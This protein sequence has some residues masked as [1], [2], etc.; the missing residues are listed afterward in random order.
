MGPL[1]ECAPTITSP[2]R[3]ADCQCVGQG[4]SG[5]PRDAA[6]PTN[7]ASPRG[8]Q[9]AQGL[10]RPRRVAGPRPVPDVGAPARVTGLSFS[11]HPREGE[12]ERTSR[13][14]GHR[15]AV[16]VVLVLEPPSVSPPI[17]PVI[18]APRLLETQ[19]PT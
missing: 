1:C 6:E 3:T 4:G 2:G 9:A 18:A 8:N 14:A 19:E 16:T 11:P 10:H 7:P 5:L 12:L 17:R 15:P 13:P